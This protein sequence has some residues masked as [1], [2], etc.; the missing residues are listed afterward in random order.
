MKWH[1][2]DCDKTEGVL[3]HSAEAEAWKNFDRKFFDFANDPRNVRLALASD[4]FNPF[5]NMSNAYSMWPVV[6]VPYNLLLWRCMKES[7]FMMSF[8][9]LGCTAP[10]NT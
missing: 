7:S 5:G 1:D 4:G 6:L 3:R 2:V 9:I 8:L 10:G